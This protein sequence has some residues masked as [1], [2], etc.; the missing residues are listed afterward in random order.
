MNCSYNTLIKFVENKLDLD[1]KLD[2]L[3]HIEKCM[4]C[5]DNVYKLEKEKD[6]K[7]FVYKR[8]IDDVEEPT[9]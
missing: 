2:T 9:S 5:F 7:H 4:S 8:Y 1:H 6:H 3:L